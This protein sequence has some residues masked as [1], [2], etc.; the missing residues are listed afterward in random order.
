LNGVSLVA[1][2]MC[3]ARAGFPPGMPMQ[4]DERPLA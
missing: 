4:P 2:S 3:G 1:I